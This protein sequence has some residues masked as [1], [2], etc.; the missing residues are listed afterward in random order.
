MGDLGCRPGDDLRLHRRR[1]TAGAGRP[2][3]APRDLR[4]GANGLGAAAGDQC[5]RCAR[6]GLGDLL[7]LGRRHRG[8][9]V[10]GRPSR[11][12]TRQLESPEDGGE[13]IV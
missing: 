5:F 7:A 13:R 2:P 1:G 12:L 8:A 6:H 11:P 4:K 10:R 3:D 9:A